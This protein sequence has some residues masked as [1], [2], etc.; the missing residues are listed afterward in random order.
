MYNRVNVGDGYF[1]QIFFSNDWKK[2][3]KFSLLKKKLKGILFY[4]F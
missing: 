1:A 3:L 2:K 4:T